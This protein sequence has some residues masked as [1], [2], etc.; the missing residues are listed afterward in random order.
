M[1]KHVLSTV[2][3]FTINWQRNKQFNRLQATALAIYSVSYRVYIILYVIGY[4]LPRSQKITQAVIFATDICV[5][6][7]KA[8]SCFPSVSRAQKQCHY[9]LNLLWFRLTK[10]TTTSTSDCSQLTHIKYKQALPIVLQITFNVSF[11][12]QNS[13]SLSKI[14]SLI[15]D[16]NIKTLF[17]AC[18]LLHFSFSL[19]SVPKI[20]RE[21][22]TS[23]K[24]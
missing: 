18:L 14:S 2:T 16:D 5:C 6:G 24:L 15:Y 17:S 22:A 7:L 10:D 1:F 20:S 19:R 12:T 4:R 23:V 9:M 3:Q 8:L 13:A 11:S 21:I